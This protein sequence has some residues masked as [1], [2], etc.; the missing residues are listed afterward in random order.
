MSQRLKLKIDVA[1]IN[2]AHIFEGK[3]GKY[4]DVTVWVNDEVDQYGQLGAVKQDWKNGDAY[5]GVI[6]GN[7]IAPKQATSTAPQYPKA[8]DA[9]QAATSEA[10]PQE[11]EK[12]ALPF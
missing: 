5:E 12:D 2:K 7:V 8:T 11:E 9:P 1:K 10:A 3:K 6:I 4:I